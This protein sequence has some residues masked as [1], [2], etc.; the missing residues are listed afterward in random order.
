M[1]DIAKVLL[2]AVVGFV[3]A[4]IGEHLKRVHTS[5]VA[6]MMIV[7][8]LAFH[9]QRLNVA[10]ILDQNPN[11]TYELKLPSPVWTAQASALLAGAPARRVE[12]ILNWYASITVLGFSI[13][14]YPGADGVQLTG[15]DRSRLSAALNDAY[16]AAVRLAR[17]WSI[18]SRT[19]APLPLF[20][21]VT[22]NRAG[23]RVT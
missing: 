23:D 20:E 11:A 22:R 8:E 10:T 2:G 14:R 21:D 1:D 16:E 19:I 7:R 13:G 12:P 4:I 6:A 5:R 18:R 15:P 3:A 9:Q 17:H